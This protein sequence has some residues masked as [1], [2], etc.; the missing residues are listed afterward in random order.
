MGPP[1]TSVRWAEL[2]A[3]GRRGPVT[4]LAAGVLLYAVDSYVVA[5]LLPS[6]I[7]EIGGERFYAW[8]TTIYLLTGVV[9]SV[10][11]SRVLAVR[12]VGP[13][14]WRSPGSASDSCSPR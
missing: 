11:V 8:V 14:C 2:V 9:A 10:L 6:A 3:P 1:S 12:R 13:T 7:A 4:L 5:S